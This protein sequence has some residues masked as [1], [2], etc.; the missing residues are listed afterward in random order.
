MNIHSIALILEYYL[1]AYHSRPPIFKR[2]SSVLVRGIDF[3]ALRA[4]FR[5]A[6]PLE[7]GF[8]ATHA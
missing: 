6:N 1:L 3:S 2:R 4:L 7:I 8:F 5:R